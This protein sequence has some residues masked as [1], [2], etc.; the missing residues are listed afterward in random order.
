MSLSTLVSLLWYGKEGVPKVAR[1]NYERAMYLK[2]GLE[3]LGFKTY[4]GPIFNEFW[5]GINNLNP[6]KQ[7]KIIPGIPYQNGLIA[8]V[9]ETKTIDDLDQYLKVAKEVL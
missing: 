2:T 8:A 7:K 4:P 5:V 3:K 1:L 6:F 9:T